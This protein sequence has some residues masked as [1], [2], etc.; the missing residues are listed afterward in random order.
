MRYSVIELFLTLFRCIVALLN[1]VMALWRYSFIDFGV[2]FS[3]IIIFFLS[4]NIVT[5]FLHFFFLDS[6]VRFF[7][8]TPWLGNNRNIYNHES[9]DELYFS[10]LSSYF[11]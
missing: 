2:F 10:Q 7:D 6:A 11:E 3:V 1:C 5:L 4:S 8:R 9:F